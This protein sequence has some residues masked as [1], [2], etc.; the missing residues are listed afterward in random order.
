[1]WKSNTDAILAMGIHRFHHHHHHHHHAV[2]LATCP[3]PFP[4][5]VLHRVRSNASSF[6]FQ[7]LPFPSRSSCSCLRLLPRLYVPSILRFI[8][9]S[10]TCYRKQFLRKML[11][12]QLASLRVT[13]CR[14]FLFSFTPCNTFH[15]SHG[16]SNWS[17]LSFANITR[18]LGFVHADVFI[19]EADHT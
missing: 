6:K 10:I 18:M 8:F 7:Y 14:M 1:M 4:Q 19:L 12:I 3:Q 5:R 15:F 9:P 17:S 16:W 13:V 11:P 2:C